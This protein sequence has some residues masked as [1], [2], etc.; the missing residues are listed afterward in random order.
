MGIIAF[1]LKNKNL[2]VISILLALFAGGG[3]YIKILKGNIATVTAEKATLVAELQ[4]SI[5]SVKSL[6]QAIKDQKTAI[7]KMKADAD[8]RQAAHQIEIN[9]AKATAD[10]YRKQAQALMDTRAQLDRPK[11]DSANDLINQEIKNAK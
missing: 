2:V 11:C 4:V 5:A 7:N 8:I 3:I 9:K 6:Q 10:T 1:L